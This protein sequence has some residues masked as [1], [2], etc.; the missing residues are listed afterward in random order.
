MTAKYLQIAREIKKRIISQQYPASAPLPD[1]FAL[2]AEFSTS[3]MTIQQAMRQLIVEG[4]IYTRK[5]QGTFVRKNFLQLSQWELPGSDYFG[6]TKPGASWR[7]AKRSGA[8]CGALSQRQG[9]KF[10]AYRRRCP[11][12]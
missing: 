10:A 6:A 8:L 4:L 3:R 2:A 11:G 9:A 1:Q 12:V 7:G 5:G